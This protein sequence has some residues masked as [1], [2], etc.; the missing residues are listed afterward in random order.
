[1]KYILFAI[2]FITLS[3]IIAIISYW[4]RQTDVDIH[5]KIFAICTQ[6]TGVLLMFSA[7][8]QILFAVARCTKN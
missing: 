1:M 5:F 2:A 3:G 7:I 8:S 6:S 4:Y